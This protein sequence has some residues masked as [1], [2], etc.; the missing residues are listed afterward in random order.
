MKISEIISNQRLEKIMHNYERMIIVTL[1]FTMMIVI[2]LGTLD[3]GW[4]IYKDVVSP[5]I[6]LLEVDELLDI[7]SFFLLILIG[8]ELLEIL[9]AY[10]KENV[11]HVEIVLVVALIAIAR[12]VI[13]LDLTEYS[14]ITVLA[15]AAVILALSVGY[16]LIKKARMSEGALKGQAVDELNK[17]IIGA[18]DRQD[19]PTQN[20]T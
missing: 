5:P 10:L 7:F 4:L 18:A 12:K 2:F 13:V 16:V 6:I 15:M 17:T 3:L 11:V 20:G 19:R 1:I 9:R 14:G 8:V